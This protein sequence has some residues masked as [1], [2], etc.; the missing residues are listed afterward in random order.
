[1]NLP[2]ALQASLLPLLAALPVVATLVLLFRHRFETMVGLR[3]LGRAKPAG[4]RIRVT[5]VVGGIAVVI[6]L[7]AMFGGR[8]RGWPVYAG[9][10][11]LMLGVF[12]ALGAA[13]LLRFS[14]FTTVSA[15]GLA[16]GVAALVVVLAVTG[17]FRRDFLTRV[18]AFHG[19]LVV[20]LYGEPSL[21]EAKT[22][23]AQ[24]KSKFAALPGVIG[25]GTFA[26]STAEVAIGP[27][28][29]SL[30]AIDPEVPSPLARWMVEGDLADLGRPATC[31]PR[32]TLR[33]PDDERGGD[34]ETPDF[35]GRLVIGRP[36]ADRVRAKVGACVDV[37]VP[38]GKPGELQPV[39]VPFQVVGIFEMGFHQHDTR[40]AYLALD[41][42]A[43][44]EKTRPFIYGLEFVFADP[45]AVTQL[46]PQIEAAVDGTHR[47]LDWRALSQGLFA[48]LETQ[49]VVIGLFLSIIILV[50]AFNL[51][52]SLIIV[53]LSK[54]REIALLGALGA[55][56]TALLRIF[57]AAGGIAGLLGTGAGMAAGLGFCALVRAF[58]FRL[59]AAV[60]M[61]TELPIELAP[62]DL[63]IVVAVAQTACLAA[64]IPPVLRARRTTI[65]DGLRYV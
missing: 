44:F 35:I 1:M 23:I 59:E 18:T 24:L 45:L 22:E 29:A 5:L 11:L 47:V 20:G 65:T 50:S 17:G 56:P 55:R 16:L 31:Q 64:T 21:A 43:A 52:A 53:V 12:T 63:L 9:A 62:G 60:Y 25:T 37:V 15:M 3:Y 51:V 30:K 19:H 26:V 57:V 8:D 34:E 28:S 13:M 46:M 14:V 39:A 38:F 10:V 33:G 40:L 61:I 2:A 4:P 49:R 54:S 41:D 58:R 36:L 6:G 48:A 42:L 27:A 7:A 32:P